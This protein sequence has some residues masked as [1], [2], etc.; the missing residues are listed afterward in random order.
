MERV[1]EIRVWDYPGKKHTWSVVFPGVSLLHTRTRHVWKPQPKP[2]CCFDGDTARCALD[3]GFSPKPGP[4]W[5]G[6]EVCAVLE[7]PFKKIN[8]RDTHFGE[9]SPSGLASWPHFLG[10]CP[11]L[12]FLHDKASSVHTASHT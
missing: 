7:A 8:G 5:F 10:R 2:S 1:D 9:F 3:K 12:E 11:E 4:P 6:T